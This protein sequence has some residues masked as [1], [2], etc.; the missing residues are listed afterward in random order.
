MVASVVVF[1][2]TTAA[3]GCEYFASS[4]KL[5]CRTVSQ[6]ESVPEPSSSDR[7][8]T[9]LEQGP[10]ASLESPEV[11]SRREVQ[12]ISLTVGDVASAEPS[13]LTLEHNFIFIERP[14]HLIS[15][16]GAP[17]PATYLG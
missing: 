16:P 12:T 10:V 5:R 9:D 11:E 17:P 7:T 15:L 4:H 3:R 14:D 13:C 1:G 2:G 8:T 6:I